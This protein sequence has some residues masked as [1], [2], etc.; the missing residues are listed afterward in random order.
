MSFT[1]VPLW[2][3]ALPAFMGTVQLA[4]ADCG[5][6]VNEDGRCYLGTWG[7]DSY[8]QCDG[9]RFDEFTQEK[10]VIT[11]TQRSPEVE[12]PAWAAGGLGSSFLCGEWLF[13]GARQERAWHPCDNMEGQRRALHS[14]GDSRN[15]LLALVRDCSF[16]AV[17]RKLARIVRR[18]GKVRTRW[19]RHRKTHPGP[20]STKYLPCPH[21]PTW[22]SHS[23]TLRK[24]IQRFHTSRLAPHR[25]LCEW[26]FSEADA[27]E[28]GRRSRRRGPRSSEARQRRLVR[29]E[30]KVRRVHYSAFKRP[31]VHLEGR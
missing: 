4:V 24:H 16:P 9:R 20:L 1:T 30:P 31:G 11:G 26:N 12:R 17:K 28:E 21:C 8:D 13:D 29:R 7:L 25:V 22:L 5:V 18:E 19:L 3:V 6:K 23:G 15:D 14:L 2:T 27:V 10:T